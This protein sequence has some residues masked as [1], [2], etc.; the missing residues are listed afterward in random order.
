[1]IPL[2]VESLVVC[3]LPLGKLFVGEVWLAKAENDVVD[4]IE[5]DFKVILVIPSNDQ[6]VQD[7]LDISPMFQ[8]VLRMILEDALHE[9]S[10]PFQRLLVPRMKTTSYR[11]NKLPVC[12]FLL[13]SKFFKSNKFFQDMLKDKW[14]KGVIDESQSDADHFIGLFMLRNLIDQL[15]NKFLREKLDLLGVEPQKKREIDVG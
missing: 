1:M 10:V 12:F 11:L 4:D 7:S 15:I 2:E 13:L 14:S 6:Q 8:Y 3:V 5:A 9:A